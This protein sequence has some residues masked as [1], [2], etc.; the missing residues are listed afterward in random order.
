MTGPR[1]CPCSISTRT[2]PRPDFR[3]R[4]ATESDYFSFGANLAN[5]LRSDVAMNAPVERDEIAEKK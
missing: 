2:A 3:A 4:L 1:A 5:E